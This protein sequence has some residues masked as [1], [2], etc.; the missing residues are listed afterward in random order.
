MVPNQPVTSG[1]LFNET[2]RG[3]GFT[4]TCTIPQSDLP[5]GSPDTVYGNKKSAKAAAAKAA[6]QYLIQ[7]GY[8]NADG[9]VKRTGKVAVTSASPSKASDPD[10]DG[11]TWAYRINELSQILGLG[12]PQYDLR[13]SDPDAGSSFF[14]VTAHFPNDITGT[15]GKVGQVTNAYGKKNAKEQCA[16][17]VWVVLDALRKERLKG[18]EK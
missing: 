9:S 7:E 2:P 11:K 16:A 5:F 8:L 17:K 18:L 12:S 10:G 1:P 14:D 4:C 15:I 13:P 6:V 3:S